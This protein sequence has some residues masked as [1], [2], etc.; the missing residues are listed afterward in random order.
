MKKI[1]ILS[2]FIC[3]SFLTTQ[4]FSQEFKAGILLGGIASQVDGDNMSGYYKAGFTGG[5]FVFRDYKENSRFQGEILF[6]MKGSRCSPKNTNPDLLQVS[7]NYIDI[8]LSYIYKLFSFLH[9]RIGIMPSVLVFSE[10]KTPT[11]LIQIADEAP[12]FRSFGLLGNAGVSYFFNDRLSINWT[13]NYSLYSIRSGNAE[14]YT[15][16]LLKEQNNQ[17]HNYMSFTLAY[18]F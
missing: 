16:W 12:A 11:N 4:V 3:F 2:F 14:I 8:N 18:Q 15:D 5:L 7:A 6:S 1:F 10:E 9:C 17:R 13:Y